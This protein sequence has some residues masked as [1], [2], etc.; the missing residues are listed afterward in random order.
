M[1]I[2][3]VTSEISGSHKNG[4]I[5]TFCDHLCKLLEGHERTLIH[6]PDVSHKTN[7]RWKTH[8]ER[9]GIRVI[10][11]R[12]LPDEEP[13]PSIAPPESDFL[14]VSRQVA[15]FI[16]QADF[17]C[18]HFQDWK[19]HGFHSIRRR[20][21]GLALQN[22]ALCVTLHSPSQWIRQG[23]QI[24]P[25]HVVP[26]IQ[27]DYA[28]RYCCEHADTLIAPTHHM[29]DWAAAEGW[30]IRGRTKVI[31]C[32]YQKTISEPRKLPPDPSHLIFFG[33]LETRKGLGI[34]LEGL[35]LTL[36]DPH[37]ASPEKITFLG[38]VAT[39][40]GLQADRVIAQFGRQYPELSIVMETQRDTQAALDY[41]LQSGGIVC[42]P[43]LLDNCPLGVIECIE[44]DI[45]F[46]AARSGGVPE[47]AR[48]D[49][50]FEPT[51]DGVHGALRGLSGQDWS[52][53]HP[54]Q[55][56]SA[57]AQWQALHDDN[58]RLRTRNGSQNQA[59][60]IADPTTPPAISVCIPY[61]NHGRYLA[62]ALESI[63]QNT[64]CNFEVIVYD[65]GSTG[66][67]DQAAFEAA[68]SRYESRGWRFLRQNN[69]GVSAAR[70][71]A[72]AEARGDYLV[73]MDADNIARPEMLETFFHAALNSGADLLTCH[74]EAFD[75]KRPPVHSKKK[76]TPAYLYRPIGP[77]FPLY[78]LENTLG[79]ANCI[80][81]RSVFESIG[82][83]RAYPLNAC[84][85]WDLFARAALGGYDLDVVPEALYWYRYQT[86]SMLR[87]ACLLHEEQAILLNLLQSAP[88]M[89]ARFLRD[90]AHPL[91][92]QFKTLNKNIGFDAFGNVKKAP[93][94]WHK[95]LYRWYRSKM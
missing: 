35:R 53:T 46:I 41:L 39:H 67:A 54:Y 94:P 45:P 37:I 70:N 73:F 12:D 29:L 6:T 27:Q 52:Q 69:Q 50:L 86:D 56:H 82:G 72:A 43:S 3:I 91:F 75:A 95:H 26:A 71:H 78:L 84:A 30:N 76:F 92:Q 59:R 36:E 58:P 55:A 79:D 9:L 60:S 34:F 20:R 5:G 11:R 7:P 18:V 63:E 68:S 61:F 24:Q 40:H 93:T 47:L 33:R 31:P 32:C 13:W 62:Q 89:Q 64:F 21:M 83:F 28:E 38:K 22:T 2:C 4:G 8:Y 85:D 65:D 14:K 23:M 74:F 77:A 49:C 15:D 17:D 81:K 16:D 87:K 42:L 51:A 19:A 80:V 25:K 88:E 1:K 66:P 48:P 10:E 90:Y 57:N 44:H